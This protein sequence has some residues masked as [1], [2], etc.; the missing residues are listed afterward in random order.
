[1]GWFSFLNPFSSNST[2]E[3]PVEPDRTKYER[4][5]DKTFI[6]PSN[7]VQFY[8]DYP[9]QGEVMY[10][11]CDH[12]MDRTIYQS[13]FDVYCLARDYVHT[14]DIDHLDSP[15]TYALCIG[16]WLAATAL[17]KANPHFNH[18]YGNKK[19]APAQPPADSSHKRQRSDSTL[20]TANVHFSNPIA[21]QAAPP[22][23]TTNNDPLLGNIND[24]LD[25]DAL[26]QKQ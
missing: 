10:G 19:Q 1:M 7:P 6:R 14:F 24:P 4:A 2:K 25:P 5:T 13:H 15:E 22:S 20:P 23:A 8:Y 12:Y 9:D 18:M 26:R 11:L 16:P 21:S 3:Q 17:E